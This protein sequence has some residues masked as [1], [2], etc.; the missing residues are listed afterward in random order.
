[1]SYA[2]LNRYA[3]NGDWSEDAETVSKIIELLDSYDFY[4]RY[5]DNYGQ[6]MDQKAKNNKIEVEL[7]HLGVDKFERI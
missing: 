4:W 2:L 6:M 7:K 5:I 3:I 1:M